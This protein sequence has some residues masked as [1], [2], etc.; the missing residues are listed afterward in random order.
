MLK[1]IHTSTHLWTNQCGQNG[2]DENCLTNLPKW[3]QVC[4]YFETKAKIVID[5]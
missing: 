3:M 2:A 5:Q 4:Y 1:L